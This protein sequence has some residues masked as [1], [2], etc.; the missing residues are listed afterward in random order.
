MVKA[1][2]IVAHPDDETIWMGGK[3]LREKN[4]S[5]VI[6]S[7]C[8]KDDPDRAPKFFRV[9]KALNAKGFISDLDDENPEKDLSLD[10]VVKR[11]E[12]IVHDKKFDFVFTHGKNGEYGHKRHIEVHNAVIE[13]YKSGLLKLKNLLCFN[14]KRNENPFMCLPNEDAQ[15]KLE[16]T[17]SEFREKQRLVHEVYGFRKDIFEYLSCS[18]TETFQKVV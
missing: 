7:L 9:C 12:P 15:E 17:D 5:W 18:K 6:L 16:L 14:Y 1:I 8:R 2:S 13:M 10:E 4:W 11:I 3:I